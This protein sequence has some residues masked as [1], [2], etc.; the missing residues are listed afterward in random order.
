MQNGINSISE[1]TQLWIIGWKL[2]SK[3]VDPDF[4]IIFIPGEKNVPL[5]VSGRIILFFQNSLKHFLSSKYLETPRC[6]ERIDLVCDV[7]KAMR[8]ISSGKTD[9]DSE[10][11]N[12]LN[13]LFDAISLSKVKLPR[14]NKTILYK[15]S[16]HLTFNKNFY[17]FIKEDFSRALIK[18]SIY[19]LIGILITNSTFW[20]NQE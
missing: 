6:V 13:F 11:L 1:E 7:E 5:T 12:M 10:I 3:R 18:E 20:E 19:L 16:D 15:F 17:F 9:T 4:Y 8:I 14:K 2:S